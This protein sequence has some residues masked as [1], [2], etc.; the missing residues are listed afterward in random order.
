MSALP[1]SETPINSLNIQNNVNE[2]RNLSRSPRTPPITSPRHNGTESSEENLSTSTSS[3]LPSTVLQLIRRER[4]ALETKKSVLQS[5]NLRESFTMGSNG[6]KHGGVLQKPLHSYFQTEP[7]NSMP[8]ATTSRVF[9][10]QKPSQAHIPSS[11]STSPSEI[12]YREGKNTYSP[13]SKPS[14]PYIQPSSSQT[15]LNPQ[16]GPNH[17]RNPLEYQAQDPAEA[18]SKSA[19]VITPKMDA[20]QLMQNAGIV[21][22]VEDAAEQDMDKLTV[23]QRRN[24]SFGLHPKYLRYNL[25]SMSTNLSP[26]TAEWSTTAFPL[27]RPPVSVLSDPISSATI[28]NYPDLFKIVTPINVDIFESLL[29]THPNPAFCNSICTALREGFWPWA[30]T[31]L[32]NYP[33]THDAS[34]ATPKDEAKISFLRSQRDIEIAKER[35]S[36]SFGQDLLPGM[37][38]MPIFAVP[39]HDSGDFR[40]V[41]DQ[42]AGNFH[43]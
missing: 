26:T 4:V 28:S 12:L 11:V 6:V 18:K 7:A 42:S 27:P 24:K 43:L 41:T 16:T 39:K 5:L 9:L 10:P 29:S 17:Y 31:I 35:F 20:R 13:T 36:A 2:S 32:P 3:S 22:S 21:T 25:W 19:T 8:M 14:H 34:Q 38:S 30:N 37:F 1:V 15:E 23:M 40:L 33:A